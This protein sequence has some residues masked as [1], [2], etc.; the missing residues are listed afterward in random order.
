MLVVLHEVHVDILHW[1]VDVVDDRRVEGRVGPAV[2]QTV[3]VT[4]LRMRRGRALLTRH[5]TAV[6]R[7]VS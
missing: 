5:G 3:A 4:A 1:E 2:T 6:S 7:S